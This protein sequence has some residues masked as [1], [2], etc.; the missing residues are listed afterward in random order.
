MTAISRWLLLTG[1]LLVVAATA[2]AT[3]SAAFPGGNGK[4][5][6][7]TRGDASHGNE[8]HGPLKTFEPGAFLVDTLTDFAAS[9]E[10]SPDGNRIVFERGS[11]LCNPHVAVINADGSG[12]AAVT[13][14]TDL[15]LEFEPAWSPD[16]RI[17]YT[18]APNPAF[19]Q[20]RSLWIV[21]SDG[22]G[23]HEILAPEQAPCYKKQ[24]AWSPDGTRIAFSG[25]PSFGDVPTDIYTVR[26][27]G[28]DLRQL[29]DSGADSASQAEWSP[30]GSE[31]AYHFARDRPQ[32]AGW[33]FEFR[34]MGA[35]GSN[36][37]L[38]RR[39]VGYASVYIDDFVMA[40]AW[41]PN[42]TLIAFQAPQSSAGEGEG[43]YAV[44]PD[45]SGLR[46][47]RAAPNPPSGLEHRD[48]DWQRVTPPPPPDPDD[49]N[50]V[51]VAVTVHNLTVQ[52][53]KSCT[54]VDSTVTGRIDVR[55]NAYFEAND[56]DIAKRVR[57]NRSQTVFIHTHSFVGHGIDA[58]RTGTVRAI[59]SSV[60]DESVRVDRATELV[61]V[62][63]MTISGDVDVRDSGD[64]IR[65]GDAQPGDCEGNTIGGSVRLKH[66]R[67]D[68]KFEVRGN[69]IAGNLNVSKNRGTAMKFVTGNSGGKLLLCRR[70]DSPFFAF[71]NPFWESRLE[72][73]SGP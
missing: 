45:G 60:T 24:A 61:E 41:A 25:A 55:Q 64:T 27:D 28:T 1:A 7:T 43:L 19:G 67:T 5:A 4:I 22:S 11:C 59:K 53:D 57:A 63:G 36:D 6:F 12:E 49:C 14:N 68:S 16:N 39:H 72:Q 8:R 44:K 17:A 23:A 9:P 2:A 35:D 48:P 65:I 52:K 31:I 3:A 54:L 71:N 58:H 46:P 29:T 69:A 73:C 21:G 10:W 37:H 40:P 42:G 70:N 33:E 51:F 30:D 13:N 26:P 66:N 32:D 47:I 38:G 56:T 34:I 62:C 20:C 18:R 50:G 15:F